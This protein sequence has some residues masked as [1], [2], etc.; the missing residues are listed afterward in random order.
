MDLP[1]KSSL[2]VFSVS[3]AA[4]FSALL[5]L[6]YFIRDDRERESCVWS[7]LTSQLKSP[8]APYI[9]ALGV[10]V[11]VDDAIDVGATTRWLFSIRLSE[12]PSWP[13]Q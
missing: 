7:K 12:T 9:P 5:L 1:A 11:V 10:V 13:A 2:F 6:I 8:R 4:C 3:C